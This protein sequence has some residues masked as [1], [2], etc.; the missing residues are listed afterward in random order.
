MSTIKPKAEW[1]VGMSIFAES[2]GEGQISWRGDGRDGRP[3]LQVVFIRNKRTPNKF[4]RSAVVR[5]SAAEAVKVLEQFRVEFEA[6]Q[7][8]TA[9]AAAPAPDP[10]LAAAVRVP[11]SRRKH[12]NTVLTGHANSER[13]WKQQYE[14]L[15]AEAPPRPPA[16][17]GLPPLK[18]RIRMRSGRVVETSSPVWKVDRDFTTH[19]RII[20]NIDRLYRPWALGVKNPGGLLGGIPRRESSFSVELKHAVSLFVARTL[21]RRTGGQASRILA[22]LIQ[23][24]AFLAAQYPEQVF[25]LSDLSER[26]Y[27]AFARK[28]G[29]VHGHFVAFYR[30]CVGQGFAGFDLQILMRL[31]RVPIHS[32]V[33]GKA[34]RSSNPR[35]GALVWEEQQLLTRALAAPAPQ[36]HPRDRLIVWL[37]QELGS[38]PSAIGALRNRHLQATPLGDAYILH[39]P[40]VKQSGPTRDLVPR[41]ISKGLGDLSRSLR[42]GGD[43]ESLIPGHLEYSWATKA[44]RAFVDANALRS[45]RL[46]AHDAQG[47]E[48]PEPLPLNPCRLRYTMG[49]N[50]AQQGASPEQIAAMLDDRTLAMA[51]VYTHNTSELV[52]ALEETLDRHPAWLRQMHLFLGKIGTEENRRLPVIQGG[53]PYFENYERYADRIQEIGWCSSQQT[54]ELRP[55]LSCYRCG[56]FLAHPDPGVHLQQLD[57]LKD[58]VRTKIGVESDRMAKVLRPDMFAIAELVT[59]TRGG[60]TAGQRIEM[61][62]AAD[63]AA[64]VAQENGGRGS[65]ASRA[66]TARSATGSI[67]PAERAVGGPRGGTR[68]REH[69]EEKLRA[70]VLVG[71]GEARNSH[72]GEGL[73][74]GEE[75]PIRAGEAKR[76]RAGEGWLVGE[77]VLARAGEGLLT[78]AGEVIL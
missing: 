11:R 31:R 72:A 57:Q 51:L 42:V 38:R 54:C 26:V 34:I 8:K 32:G 33:R 12:P 77:E 29:T 59:M 6:T 52:D 70:Q 37:F 73:L 56:W 22:E 46:V 1:R 65:P 69:G 40:R 3:R 16:P 64:R 41:K 23:F 2:T 9:P 36:T 71:A 28:A 21:E 44:C 5:G 78:S 50:L 53:V 49:T 43:D 13:H 61:R 67:S 63:G 4:Y 39:V 62:I 15:V 27:R 74:V 55:P 75:V 60:A 48:Q 7:P 47:V 24:E 18:P 45:P 19:R 14:A 66:G 10:A 30:W 58:E 25:G 35:K 20:L 68:L 76:P 17:A